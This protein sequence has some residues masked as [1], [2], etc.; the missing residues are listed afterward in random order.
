MKMSQEISKTHKEVLNNYREL[1]Q[2]PEDFID[3]FLAEY[4]K[5]QDYIDFVDGLTDDLDKKEEFLKNQRDMVKDEFFELIE[6]FEELGVQFEVYRQLK[7]EYEDFIKELEKGKFKDHKGIGIYWS[8]NKENAETVWED[9]YKGDLY[10]II[11][12]LIYKS[13]VDWWKT[14]LQRTHPNYEEEDEIRLKEGIT[15]KIIEIDKN[16]GEEIIPY[17]K[18]IITMIQPPNQNPLK[19]KIIL[20]SGTYKINTLKP[21]KHNCFIIDKVYRGGE[22]IITEYIGDHIGANTRDTGMLGTGLYVYAT[23]PSYKGEDYKEIN[24]RDLCFYK[25]SCDRCVINTSNL[26]NQSINYI[27]DVFLHNGISNFNHQTSKTIHKAIKEWNEY[28]SFQK[29]FLRMTPNS[30][31]KIIIQIFN[32]I[33]EKG[34]DNTIQPL[35]LYLTEKGFDG[36][37]PNDNIASS[38]RWGSIIF[39]HILNN[40]T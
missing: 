28:E 13:D 37:I 24:T 29:A 5:D 38:N 39:P 27:D 33:K 7:V 19:N 35:T 20:K 11:T 10:I 2:Y 31:E 36:L 4:E 3:D 32:S 26:L 23:K 30:I 6:V 40:Q 18:E 25:T 8:L 22:L 9:K 1:F 17:A 34:A 14:L 12:A 16:W 15:I 21:K